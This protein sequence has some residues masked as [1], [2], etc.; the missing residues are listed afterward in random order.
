M[1]R[2][3]P[4]L[5][6]AIAGSLWWMVWAEG[7]PAGS[8]EVRLARAPA[9]VVSRGQTAARPLASGVRLSEGD[10]V[11]TGRGGAAEIQLG[12]GSLVRVG[13][14]SELEIDRLDV[15]ATGAPTTSRFNLAAG[16]ARAWV[17]R[18][19]IAKVATGQGRFAVQTPTA[20]SAV[21]Q[22][23]FAVLHDA[24]A[25]TRVYTFEGTVETT[26]SRVGAGSV[27]CPRN[28][29]TRV[30][31]GRDPVPCAVIPL[32]DK[33][34]VLKVLVFRSATV[35]P[36]DP[37]LAALHNMGIKLSDEKL[38]GAKATGGSSIAPGI[39][40]GTGRGGASSPGTV[41]ITVTTD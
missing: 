4:V 31:P 2:M 27:L 19:V 35:G 15:D 40:G 6:V 8:A 41:N 12:D 29:W 17:A 3:R 22:T 1:T 11:R 25:V 20:V 38:T 7:Q 34:S 10:R 23:D 21:R 26:A 18:Q 14:L 32:R 5:M 30:E 39:P 13:E 28:R 16:Q 9:D 24:D 36:G 33:R 37:D